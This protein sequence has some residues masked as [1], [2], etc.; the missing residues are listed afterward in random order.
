MNLLAL[1]GPTDNWVSVGQGPDVLAIGNWLSFG[2][3]LGF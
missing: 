2:Q 3:S 1:G